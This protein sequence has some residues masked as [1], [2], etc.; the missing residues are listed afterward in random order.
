MEHARQLLAGRIVTPEIAVDHE[1]VAVSAALE[2]HLR[3]VEPALIRSGQGVFV[4]APLI[5][6]N[7]GSNKYVWFHPHLE[8]GEAALNCSVSVIPIL[9][10]LSTTKNLYEIRF[11]RF[12][13]NSP[14]NT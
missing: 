12:S 11:T 2:P 6:R 4:R 1:L 5:K 7:I 14:V 8:S 13:P 9:P 10:A 3:R